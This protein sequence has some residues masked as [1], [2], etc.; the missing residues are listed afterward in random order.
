MAIILLLIASTDYYLEVAEYRH[1][2]PPEWSLW[3]RILFRFAIAAEDESSAS[4]GSINWVDVWIW[5]KRALA[6]LEDINR[7]DGKGIGEVLE[8]GIAISRDGSISA[9]LDVSRK[10]EPWRRG[11]YDVLMSMARAAEHIEGWVKD[12]TQNIYFPPE[13]V[14]G[15]D[16][17]AKHG[18]DTT[19]KTRP[20]KPVPPEKGR[21]PLVSNCEVV[22][23]SP[24]TL[25]SKILTSR[26]FTTTQRVDAALAYASWLEF[27]GMYD[28]A[29]EVYHWALDIAASVLTDG[30][31]MTLKHNIAD[32]VRPEGP[33]PSKNILKTSTAYAMHLASYR[34]D[35]QTALSILLSVL[36]ARRR[37][38]PDPTITSETVP[39]ALSN[40]SKS[41]SS[42]TESTSYS[43]IT[44]ILHSRRYP[45]P[46]P[47]GDDTFTRGQTSECD[48]AAIMLNVGEILFAT[49]SQLIS[50]VQ[51]TKQG[52]QLAESR[53][54]D[55]QRGTQE[56][57]RCKDCLKVGLDNWKA[58]MTNLA[59]MEREKLGPEELE[60][61][62]VE[63]KLDVIG[64]KEHGENVDGRSS[65]NPSGDAVAEY[66]GR[67][68]GWQ[69]EERRL[70]AW[71]TK[72]KSE[73]FTEELRQYDNPGNWFFLK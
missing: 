46:P 70:E 61:E 44:S 40:A 4:T 69:E 51:W 55:S 54:R 5:N 34:Q 7:S 13:Y 68:K 64:T 10:S 17:L 32:F 27:K 25:Y 36:A 67:G 62:K 71:I 42:V 24:Q 33:I 9:G 35:F 53:W 16:D 52:T 49:G 50:G 73:I 3:T 47:S 29:K 58:M 26:G 57:E 2:S 14:V 59:R 19:T 56:R 18:P 65:R 38:L 45:P 6:R 48:D 23:S 31:A 28:A 41:N 66:S 72:I 1:P 12:R 21:P 37:A 60:L 15:D 20:P 22:A 30:T 8:G 63:L 11:Y 39:P 43:F